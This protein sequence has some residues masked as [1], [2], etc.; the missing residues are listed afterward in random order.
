MKKNEK[1][2]AYHHLNNFNSSVINENRAKHITV[3]AILSSIEGHYN[4]LRHNRESQANDEKL[5]FRL[6]KGNPTL[7]P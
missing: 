3:A 7:S 6:K 1:A 5:K 2:S 4:R